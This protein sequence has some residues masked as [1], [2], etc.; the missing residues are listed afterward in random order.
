M[1]VI[2]LWGRV[3]RSSLLQP[4]KILVVL[5][6]FEKTLLGFVR[7]AW[8]GQLSHRFKFRMIN[9]FPDPTTCRSLPEGFQGERVVIALTFKKRNFCLDSGLQQGC[10][11]EFEMTCSCRLPCKRSDL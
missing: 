3:G 8:D 9:G 2:W 4:E 7:Q 11:I 1:I 10:C 5:G 6:C